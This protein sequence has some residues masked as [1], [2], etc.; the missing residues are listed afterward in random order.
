GKV[1]IVHS[2]LSEGE[3]YDTWRRARDGL[4]Q[5]VVGPRSAMFTPLPEVGLI[6]IDKEHDQS[7]KHSEPMLPPYSHVRQ[8]A[9]EMMRRNNGVLI[10]GSA[11]PDVETMFRAQ[12]GDIEL[13]ELPS[14]IMGHRVRITEESERVGVLPLYHPTDAPDALTIDLPPVEVV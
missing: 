11:T 5:V 8:V 4:V 6:L 1:A 12:R 2:Q 10:L 13:L 9:E 7:Y 3:R 14:R